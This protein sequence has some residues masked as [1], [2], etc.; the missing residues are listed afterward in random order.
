MPECLECDV[1]QKARYI[2]QLLLPLPFFTGRQSSSIDE[3]CELVSLN[4][5]IYCMIRSVL[6]S[7][8]A[9]LIKS[10]LKQ[11]L[12]GHWKLSGNVFNH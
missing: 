11:V 4:V 2:K 8:T 1:L 6:Y 12:L 9:M 5:N 7:Q 10:I 3:L